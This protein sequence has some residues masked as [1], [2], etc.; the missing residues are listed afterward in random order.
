MSVESPTLLRSC[1]RSRRTSQPN[2]A[3]LRCAADFRPSGSP[4]PRLEPARSA[5]ASSGQEDCMRCLTLLVVLALA[6]QGRP[7]ELSPLDPGRY[8]L[9]DLT[10]PLNYHAVF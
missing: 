6:A 10:H 5:R 2:S 4:A 8:D 1:R 9:I 3:T 7:A